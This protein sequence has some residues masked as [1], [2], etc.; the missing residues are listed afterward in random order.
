[1]TKL[2]QTGFERFTVFV[3]RCAMQPLRMRPA[4]SGNSLSRNFYKYDEF[5]NRQIRLYNFFLYNLS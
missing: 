1:M 4:M 5:P 2:L 3:I